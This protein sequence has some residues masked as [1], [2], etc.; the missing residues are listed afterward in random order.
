MDE[1][2]NGILFCELEN[3]QDLY[4]IS[5][6]RYDYKNLS[7]IKIFPNING[8]IYSK[9][10]RGVHYAGFINK[11]IECYF[12]WRRSEGNTPNKI[13]RLKIKSFFNSK[14]IS[15]K[16]KVIR[17]KGE[18]AENKETMIWDKKTK[19]G[20]IDITSNCLKSRIDLEAINADNP[21]ELH[22][23]VILLK[24]YNKLNE[25]KYYNEKFLELNSKL[26]FKING[27]Q[28]FSKIQLEPTDENN[29]EVNILN[30][31][32]FD[33]FKI[34]NYEEIRTKM[35]LF[36]RFKEPT[37]TEIINDMDIIRKE[38]QDKL[39]S[40]INND[41]NIF[42]LTILASIGS[43][44]TTFLRRIGYNLFL[45]GN[46]VIFLENITYFSKDNVSYLIEKIKYFSECL[47]KSKIF[48][49]I[50]N[51]FRFPIKHFL[52]KIN[53]IKFPLTIIGTSQ[54]LE[55][56]KDIETFS[57]NMET[58]LLSELNENEARTFAFKLLENHII[59]NIESK[60]NSKKFLNTIKSNSFIGLINTLIVDNKF[61]I[62][63]ENLLNKILIESDLTYNSYKFIALTYRVGVPFPVSLLKRL[64]NRKLNKS[65]DEED[66]IIHISRYAKNEIIYTSES[67]TLKLNHEQWGVDATKFIFKNDN[68][69]KDKYKEICNNLDI[70]NVNE[71]K[72]IFNLLNGLFIR[73]EFNLIEEFYFSKDFFCNLENIK[74]VNQFMEWL[75]Y[76]LPISIINSS[77][78]ILNA[79]EGIFNEM[80][81]KYPSNQELYFKSKLLKYLKEKYTDSKVIVE[82]FNQT[83]I[84]ITDDKFERL[85]INLS[86]NSKS[87]LYIKNYLNALDERGL[88]K[89]LKH[90][91]KYFEF[92]KEN[93]KY[94]N[95][96]IEAKIYFLLKNDS[97]TNALICFINNIEYFQNNTMF[98]NISLIIKNWELYHSK[99]N[100]KVDI[101][102]YYKIINNFPKD[103]LEISDFEK[104]KLGV[105][106]LRI[107]IYYCNRDIVHNIYNLLFD[108]RESISN[109]NILDDI[110]IEL[111]QKILK[112]L[113]N[114]G[115]LIFFIKNLLKILKRLKKESLITNS[116]LEN[117]VKKEEVIMK[118][119]FNK[120]DLSFVYYFFAELYI[121]LGDYNASEVFF[122]KA[123][124]ISSNSAEI[125]NNYGN[126]LR[127]FK[128]NYNQA[129][130]L[131]L[132][133][134]EID[135]EFKILKKGL[136]NPKYSYNLAT[137]IIEAN[138]SDKFTKA[139][140]ILKTILDDKNISDIFKNFSA[141]KLDELNKL[142]NN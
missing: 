74:D 134:I 73:D 121:L 55:Y 120:S 42:L 54:E 101:K 83:G 23:F 34:N 59:P 135:K 132:K 53:N 29:L 100:I 28:L 125:Y 106:L 138:F 45:D 80:I 78:D 41:H 18:I 3:S 19:N 47:N 118:I 128:K 14:E 82:H 68:H 71:K 140:E 7:N 107:L 86:F 81:F 114:K 85:L 139:A 12:D 99:I 103:L 77:E 72:F 117:L 137:L 57:I 133:S 32:Y 92:T 129:E 70:T 97:H 104:N 136:P 5:F 63:V 6:T 27:N 89:D 62:K 60:I 127:D 95:K 39:H 43:G 90:I 25:Y 75:T 13:E 142:L 111:N 130:L 50:D 69:L 66:L 56:D 4:Y 38:N 44:K 30:K 96:L 108:L 10:P 36:Y 122:E 1:I 98:E 51:C 24:K 22:K 33:S 8:F 64:I 94:F 37:W 113:T 112:F 21:E 88:K 58:L 20:I 141:N 102:N 93:I 61:H 110:F 84:L 67:N 124:S 109:K 116:I 87:S 76:C 9:P 15:I 131:Y 126:Y 40:L 119:K 65:L 16:D 123:I 2:K 115:Y 11:I 79:V 31:E 46:N 91:F 105:I 26:I 52:N 49:L 48:L 17:I 35:D